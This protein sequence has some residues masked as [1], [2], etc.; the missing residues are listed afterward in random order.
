MDPVIELRG[1]TKRFDGKRSVTALDNIDLRIDRG[2]MVSM[3]GPSGSGKSTLLNLIGGL[4]HAT[5]GEI[6]IDGEAV[7]GLSSD[8]LTRIRRDKIGFIFQFFNLLP[9]LSCL[10][11][12]AIPLHLRGWPRR[13]ID[14][15]A[16]ELLNR[17]KLGSRLDHLPDE[18]SGGE[19]QRVA[20]ARA[21]SVYPPILLADEPT[22]NL[23]SHTGADILRLMHD[24]HDDLGSTILIVTHERD[25]RG[26]LPAHDI[27]ERRSHRKGRAP[28]ILLRLITWPYVRKHLARTVLT[29]AGIVLG[30]A[31]FVGMHTANQS[32]LRAFYQTIDRIAG[33]TQLQITAGEP[34]FAEEI[35]EK[36]Q[37]H[38]DVRVAVPVIEAVVNPPFPNAGSLLILAVDMTGD[39]SLR[40]YDFESG[41]ESIIDDPL[42]FLAQSDSLIIASNFAQEHRLGINSRIDL[43]TMDG[44]KRFTVRGIMKPGGLTSAFGGSLAVMDVYAAQK[45][46]GRGRRF[47]RIDL[48][49]R[50]GAR[51]EDV[52]GSVQQLLGPGYQVEAPGAR[53]EQ[54]ENLSQSTR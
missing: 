28:M 48:A 14:E 19:R 41:E 32:V 45:V 18:L 36:V 26:E 4:D 38:P 51:V 2:E 31:V 29:L 8:E 46:F 10:E 15:R 25:R 23:D 37:S 43:D 11:N 42:I 30:V 34:G 40:D 35:L 9:T 24:L 1:V 22:G 49:V 33:T 16:R 39:R 12:V 6:R 53:G 3:V 17:V 20:I 5:S 7:A 47:D 27:A 44:R 52:Q 50:D 21:L 13:K 54:F